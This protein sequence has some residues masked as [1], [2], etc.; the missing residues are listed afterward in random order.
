MEQAPSHSSR[1]RACGARLRAYIVIESLNTYK[2]ESL[3]PKIE[4]LNHR[5]NN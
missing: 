5:M 4:S 2:I 1:L 3:N